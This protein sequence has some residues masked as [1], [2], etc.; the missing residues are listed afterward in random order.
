MI[1]DMAL[2]YFSDS[3]RGTKPILSGLQGTWRA[4]KQPD[5]FLVNHQQRG[6][7]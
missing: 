5:I 7:F 3:H 4:I 1:E 2:G 6:N